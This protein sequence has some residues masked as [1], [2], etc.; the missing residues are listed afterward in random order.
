MEI[1]ARRQLAV[2]QKTGTQNGT[3][4]NRNMDQNLRSNSWW[5]HF[6]PYPRGVDGGG[7]AE[8]RPLGV[9]QRHRGPQV[10][11]HVEGL[12]QVEGKSH[13][14]LHP[15][16][17]H[18]REQERLPNKNGGDSP[19]CGIARGFSN[20]CDTFGKGAERSYA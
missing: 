15:H 18:L 17:T 4:V 14:L 11:A 19:G 6:D 20:H 5:L 7:V 16:G 9:V 2:G 8:G 1:S 3:L 13:G 12:R 10:R